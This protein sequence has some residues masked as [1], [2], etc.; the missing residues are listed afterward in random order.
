M[1]PREARV[2]REIRAGLY[3]A[4][5]LLGLLGLAL[6]S[7]CATTASFTA[8]GPDWETHRA[9]LQSLKSWQAR[10]KILVRDAVSQASHQGSKPGASARLRWSQGGDAARLELSGPLGASPVI[11]EISEASHKKNTSGRI[12][13]DGTWGSLAAGRE[14]LERDLGWPLPLECLPWWLRGLPAPPGGGCPSSDD[15]RLDLKEARLVRLRQGGW[16]LEYADY[17]PYGGALL[18]GSIRFTGPPAGKNQ[19]GPK[20]AASGRILLRRWELEP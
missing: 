1:P 19:S 2:A 3:A 14:A 7:A 6:L 8:P 16:T 18:P 15:P 13:R 20:Q 9:Q 10:G 5:P 4:L 12:F 17:R 11:V